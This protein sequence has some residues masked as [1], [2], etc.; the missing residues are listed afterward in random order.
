MQLARSAARLFVGRLSRSRPGLNAWMGGPRCAGKL[1]AASALFALG[2]R[3]PTEVVVE[4]STD[5]ACSDV[6]DTN[7][8]SGKLIQIEGAVPATVTQRCAKDTGRIGSIVIVPSGGDSDE[9]A[10]RVVTGFTKSAQDC[11]TDGYMGGCIVARRALAFFAAPAARLARADGGELHRRALFGEPDL[12]QRALCRREP[13]GPGSLRRSCRLS[14]IGR[15]GWLCTGRRVAGRPVGRHDERG[16]NP[17]HD[18]RFGR[19]GQPRRRG[20]V[21]QRGD[22]GERR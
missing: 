16:R 11:I 2:C 19:C 7:I 22:L 15:R 12:S 4:I 14:G 21:G 13:A 9:F 20:S 18:R 10:L 5:A 17:G 1:L 8:T 6:R 3:E